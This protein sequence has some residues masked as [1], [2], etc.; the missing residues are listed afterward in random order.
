MP[1]DKIPK[2]VTIT[3]GTFVPLGV[4]LYGRRLALSFMGGYLPSL[5]EGVMLMEYATIITI[6]LILSLVLA[7]KK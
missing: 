2:C 7:L 5:F 4:I 3:N 1:V 6:V